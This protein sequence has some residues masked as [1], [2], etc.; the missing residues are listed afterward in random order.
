MSFLL[1]R[2]LTNLDSDVLCVLYCCERFARRKAAPAPYLKI[3]YFTPALLSAA[4]GMTVHHGPLACHVKSEAGARRNFS[5][6]LL[7]SLTMLRWCGT[8]SKSLIFPLI[9]DSAL[10][11][12]DLYRGRQWP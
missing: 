1:T 11:G 10:A 9:C 7:Q 3:A 5:D 4:E 12:D 2:E 8:G 6:R